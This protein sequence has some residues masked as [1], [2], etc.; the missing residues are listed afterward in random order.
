[1][2]CT[3]SD[4]AWPKEAGAKRSEI[5]TETAGCS[6]LCKSARFGDLGIW[7][8]LLLAQPVPSAA[9]MLPRREA[10]DGHPDEAE[11]GDGAVLSKSLLV[12]LY[13]TLLP[14]LLPDA[15]S[16]LMLINSKHF[17]SARA[18]HASRKAQNEKTADIRALQDLASN[19][20]S[21]LSAPARQLL[22][23]SA[24]AF[25]YSL[26]STHTAHHLPSS[27]SFLEAP[28][29]L[30]AA[31][32][33]R[34]SALAQLLAAAAV[35][36][37]GSGGP[38]QAASGGP[39]VDMYF[40][41][42]SFWRVQSD[43]ASLE[44]K[45]LGRSGSAVTSVS[46]YAGGQSASN[47]PV[48]YHNLEYPRRD[49]SILGHA[50]A[51][52]VAGIPA[53]KVGDFAKAFLDSVPRTP[54]PTACFHDHWKGLQKPKQFNCSVVVCRYHI[55]AIPAIRQEHNFDS[56]QSHYTTLVPRSIR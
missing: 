47:Q 21:R 51:V 14:D 2:A 17:S 10:T 45:A 38:A 16:W 35:A 5:A 18:A 22:R 34:R 52:Q 49:Y 25:A 29:T 1:M 31:D 42:G 30:K 19:M 50:E 20:R 46:G 15:L 48:C 12:R 36:A 8:G 4:A 9:K 53:E 7:G 41:Q 28:S 6:E 39:A 26:A 13:C 37:A 11:V 3:Q 43:F 55:M 33:R 23:W 24:L 54:Q 32:E 44:S 56:H 27:R 40:G